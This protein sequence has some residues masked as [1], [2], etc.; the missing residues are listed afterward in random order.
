VNKKVT[1]IVATL[2]GLII[3]STTWAAVIHEEKSLYR[4]I[5]VKESVNRRCLVFA[6]KKGDRNQTCMDLTDPQKVVFP[7]ARMTFAGLLLNPQPSSILVIGLGGGTIP[8]VLATLYPDSQIDV[9]EIDLAV[10]D[11]ARK[12]F[13]YSESE[14]SRVYVQDARVFIKR[15]GLRGVTYDLVILDAF[16]GDYIPEHL[17]T[18]E[19][20]EETARLLS[21]NGVLVANTFSTSALYDHESVTYNKVFPE[22]INFKM[23]NTGN[24]VIIATIKPLPSHRTMQERAMK[25]TD[26]LTTYSIDIRSF[27]PY[28]KRTKDWRQDVRPLTDQYSPANLLRN[29]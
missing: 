16:T 13:A 4:N 1:I 21:P 23:P 6:I 12:Y 27:L 19:F 29:N 7:Y 14:R 8:T 25:L 28:L 18:A 10:V 15:A 9:V 2:C 20:I 24:R 3:F 17:M 11:V 22:F 26:I 5:E